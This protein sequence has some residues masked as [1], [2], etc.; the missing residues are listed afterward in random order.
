M[1]SLRSENLGLGGRGEP[2]EIVCRP[3][4]V[5]RYVQ[6]P[7][8]PVDTDAL[9]STLAEIQAPPETG[10]SQEA[11]GITALFVTSALGLAA[12]AKILPLL[13]RSDSEPK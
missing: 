9:C 3:D 6:A 8:R 11:L 13:N 4:A 12:L 1:L 5:I 10:I 2:Y 7:G